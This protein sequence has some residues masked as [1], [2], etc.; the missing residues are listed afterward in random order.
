M[1]IEI[2][3]ML[4][5]YWFWGLL[6]LAVLAWYSSVTIYVAVRG[7]LDIKHMFG[8]LGQRR[9]EHDQPPPRATL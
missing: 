6:V 8:R 4:T 5:H 3:Q 2:Q 9:A 7:L 1:L